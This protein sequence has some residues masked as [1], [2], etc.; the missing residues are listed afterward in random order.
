[1]PAAPAAPPPRNTRT[2]GRHAAPDPAPTLPRP[3]NPPHH[4]PPPR[5]GGHTA[6]TPVEP[7][8]AARP[9]TASRAGQTDNATQPGNAGRTSRTARHDHAGRARGTLR[10]IAGLG[11]RLRAMTVRHPAIPRRRSAGRRRRPGPTSRRTP[12]VRRVAAD[13]LEPIAGWVIRRVGV[14]AR[15]WQWLVGAFGTVMML[16]VC[17]LSSCLILVDERRG[18]QATATEVA[19]APSVLPRDISSRLADPQPLTPTEVFP[20]PEIA[21]GAGEAPYRVLKTQSS[22]DCRTAAAGDLGKL[23]VRMGCDQVVRGTLRSPNGAYL[24]T[25]GIFNLADADGANQAH[26]EIKSMMPDGRDRFQGM[27]AGAGTEPIVLSSAQVGW[28]V[29]GHFLTYCVIA[30]ADG[31]AIK[32]GDQFAEQILYDMVEVHLRG[33]VL[34]RRATVPASG[35]GSVTTATP[36]LTTPR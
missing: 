33:E 32:A 17:G 12:E 27:A 13:L 21:I 2:G 19:P 25:A 15:S 7:T 18:R 24:V 9:S 30:R 29:R 34:G 26:R 31:T 36:T 11:P 20:D 16:A 10:W 28:H 1:M 6:T 3:P 5:S 14:R 23:L 22:R 35:A 4:N 8:S